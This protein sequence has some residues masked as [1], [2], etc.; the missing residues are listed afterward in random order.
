V[1]ASYPDVSVI[2]FAALPV[3]AAMAVENPLCLKILIIVLIM[4]VFPVPGPPVMT[5]TP[6]WRDA[7]RGLLVLTIDPLHIMRK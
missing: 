4:V 2:L 3:G 5:E 7:L 1:D 6:F